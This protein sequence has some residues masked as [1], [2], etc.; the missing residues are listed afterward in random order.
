M[1]SEAVNRPLYESRHVISYLEAVCP[2]EGVLM[3]TQGLG[4][5]PQARLRTVGASAE[6]I[7]Q[8]FCSYVNFYSANTQICTW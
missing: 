2:V 6:K 8:I 1:Y 7:S 5:I 4:R 3:V